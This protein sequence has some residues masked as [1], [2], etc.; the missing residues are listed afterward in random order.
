MISLEPMGQ[1]AFEKYMAESIP[2]FARDKVASGQWSEDS[3]LE[4]SRQGFEALLPEGLATHDNH[5]FE[6]HVSGEPDAIGML[7]F[8]VQERAGQRIAYVYDVM[9]HPRHQRMGHGT[10][11]FSA[12]EERARALGLAGIALHVFGHNPEAHNL[13]VRL[14]FK[15]T[16]I[17]MFKPL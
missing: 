9:I 17:S 12:L 11:T 6:I 1:P 16:N 2:A 15:P 14:G 3:A 8:A 13:Y 4:L 5:L 10:R 7:W